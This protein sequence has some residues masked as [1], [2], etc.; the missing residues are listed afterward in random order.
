MKFRIFTLLMLLL[1]GSLS[2]QDFS[3]RSIE[4]AI[5]DELYLL[6]EQQIWNALSIDRT[7]E[8]KTELT[9][10]L[11]Q[12]LIGQGRF[13]DAVILSDESPH[14]LHQDAFTYWKARAQFEAGLI[15]P[16]FQTLENLPKNSSY[17]PAALRLKGRAAVR[18]GELKDAEKFFETFEKKFPDNENAAQNLLDL[19]NV[20]LERGRGRTAVKTFNKLLERFPDS[21]EADSA[22]L[23]LARE[24]L[25]DGGK[26]ELEEAG[27][28]LRR[29]GSTET[30]HPR[31]RITAWVELA[32][33]EQSAGRSA[34]AADALLNAETLT[35]ETILRIRQKTARANLLVDEGNPKQA[36]TLFDEA[37]QDAPDEN[38]A[39]EILIQKAEAL[40]ETDRYEEADAAFQSCLNVTDQVSIQVRAFTGKG[41]SLW[42]L[43]RYEE[44]AA[45]FEQAAAKCTDSN[46]CA[47]VRTKAGDARFAAGQFEKAHENYHAV[48]ENFADNPLAARA[49]YQSGVA[50]LKTGDTDEARLHFQLTESDFPD[51]EFAPR[52]ALQLAGMLTG[53]PALQE[54]IR[55]A[56]QYTNATTRAEALH[57]QGQ[58][59]FKFNRFSDALKIFDSVVE[60]YPDAEQAPQAFYMR[61]FCRYLQGNVDTAMVLFREFIEQYPDSPWTPKVF[62]LIGEHA[63]NNGDY[64]QAQLTFVN[65]AERFPQHELAD[66]S[67]FWTGNAQL[68]SDSFL[69]A[70]KTYTR[71]AKEYPQ[72]DLLLQTRFAQGEALTELGEFPRAILAYEEIIKNEPD[73]PLSARALG[74]LGDCLFTLGS[75]EPGRYQEAIKSY[76]SLYKRPGIPFALK[77]QALYKI[78]RCEEKTGQTDQAFTHY[79]EAVYSI[80]KQTDPL[81]PEAVLWFTRA[82][83]EAATQQ[84]MNQNWKEAVNI[85]DRIIQAEVPARNE[86]EKRIQ[87]IKQE[88]AENF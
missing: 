53:E 79:M 84:E 73:G 52:A 88:H 12:S 35:G 30:A 74:R 57:Q 85:Y 44:S 13:D 11:V 72:S 68:K 45:A 77:L 63:Y 10:M 64:E 54:Y 76:Q 51:S 50:L 7:I 21:V 61:G 23:L 25:A 40:L 33:L 67:L 31:L 6:A 26:K 3:I 39:T 55:I 71:L 59:L 14:L 49:N 43:K 78:A 38:I 80:G 58:I 60:S 34:E 4:G 16:V 32:G 65:L 17:I 8:E 19:A 56:E 82:A 9:L 22:R 29:L 36:F 37:I 18:D 15:D 1:A 46:E 69:E 75:T 42:E 20:N 5:E 24:R 87:K 66:D 62:F 86:A 41:W 70:F 2:A 27:E 47:I 83:F 48:T 81:S 28:L